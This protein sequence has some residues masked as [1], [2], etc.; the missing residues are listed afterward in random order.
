MKF[1]KDFAEFLANEVN[2]NKT[3]VEKLKKGMDAVSA[4]ASKMEEYEGTQTQGSYATKTIIKPPSD[5]D[6]DLDLLLFLDP[7]SGHTPS[8]RIDS[9]WEH[10]NNSA[11]YQG[12]ATRKTR[13]VQL[14]YQDF[15]IDIVP[16]VELTDG[17]CHIFNRHENKTELTDG[18]GYRD[19]FNS[20]NSNTGGE[21]KRCVR[22]LKY[23]RDI[24]Q[25]FT[26]KSVT[27]TTLAGLASNQIPK[28][29]CKTTPDALKAITE[30][31]NQYLIN[32]P[33]VPNV[34]NPALPSEDLAR[35]WS[36]E[37][38]EIFRKRFNTITEN[39]AEAYDCEDPGLSTQKWR[40]IFGDKFR[41]HHNSGK[42]TGH[43]FTT[44]KP[45][46]PYS[47]WK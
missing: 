18:S 14:K 3:R 33:T 16:A 47:A 41:P 19:W 42:S 25:T 7:N 13:C 8:G 21:L 36:Q 35:G 2:I 12:K 24:K 20:M 37:K 45:A 17:T 27:L 30:R 29:D 15:H 10:F 34:S 11:V 4:H 26:I 39:I 32:N 31:I 43:N 46:S 5:K 23:V 28:E 44:S 9:V 22:L 38:Y 40:K 1:E 6:Y